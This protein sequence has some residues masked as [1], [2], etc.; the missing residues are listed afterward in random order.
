MPISS[1]LLVDGDT[2]HVNLEEAAELPMATQIDLVIKV[3][4]SDAQTGKTS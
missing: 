1:D 4:L 3:L 2:A